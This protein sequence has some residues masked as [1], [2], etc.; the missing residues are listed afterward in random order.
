MTVFTAPREIAQM[1]VDAHRRIQER[2][3]KRKEPADE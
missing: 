2:Q 1:L 3:A